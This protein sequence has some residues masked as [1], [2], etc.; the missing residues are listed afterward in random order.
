MRTEFLLNDTA[1]FGRPY[2]ELL[3]CFGFTECELIGRRV[4][5]CPAGPDSFVAEGL[6][7]GICASGVDPMYYR[8]PDAIARLARADF[9]D[10]YRRI[11][12]SPERFSSR[13]YATIEESESVRS[14]SLE[15]FLD[16]YLKTYPNGCYVVAALPDLP[17][18]NDSFDISICGHF[19]FIYAQLFDEG[20]HRKAVRE[21]ARVT[22]SEIRIHPLV[23]MDGERHAFVDSVRKELVLAGMETEIIE[24]D[25]EFFKG[26]NQ[27]LVARF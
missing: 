11:R 19:F 3:R 16:H 21:L 9:S 20:F 24:V 14:D 10:I 23:G 6:K 4:L 13:T 15:V 22:H 12:E 25:H 7:R 27:T 5:D 2:E 1:F 26:T 8:S 17:F 18:K